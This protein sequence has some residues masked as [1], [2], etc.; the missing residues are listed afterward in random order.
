MEICGCPEANFG[1][2]QARIQCLKRLVK[3][4]RFNSF[5]LQLSGH[6]DIPPLS[7]ALRHQL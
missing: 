1:P 3:L 7:F 5:H 4:G 6:Q 2:P